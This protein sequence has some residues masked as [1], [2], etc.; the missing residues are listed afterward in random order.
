MMECVTVSPQ[1]VNQ[2][3]KPLTEFVV[4]IWRQLKRN[5]RPESLERYSRSP[6]D[7]DFVSV[8]VEFDK[9]DSRATV[10]A[11]HAVQSYRPRAF[12]AHESAFVR[13]VQLT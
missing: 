4:D 13:P 12:R 10:Q 8:N 9:V 2:L 11:Y 6:Q 7:G 3:L 1:Q 5:Y